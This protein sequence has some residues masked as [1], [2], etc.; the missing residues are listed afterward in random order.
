MWS[1][2]IVTRE[3][4][5]C[6]ITRSPWPSLLDSGRSFHLTHRP[7]VSA[8]RV[9]IPNLVVGYVNLV[10]VCGWDQNAEQRSGRKRKRTIQKTAGQFLMLLSVSKLRDLC[11][12]GMKG[13]KDADKLHQVGRRSASASFRT[14]RAI[15][16]RVLVASLVPACVRLSRQTPMFTR[17][18]ASVRWQLSCVV[19]E[20]CEM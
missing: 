5:F 16:G 3:K 11:G 7:P 9:S 6:P 10:A 17:S 13:A 20:M 2:W 4:A 14:W 15:E 12:G 19:C 18:R 1:I 8:L